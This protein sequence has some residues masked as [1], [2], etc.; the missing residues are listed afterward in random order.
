MEVLSV[1]LSTCGTN[2]LINSPALMIFVWICHKHDPY[3]CAFF[4]FNEV[5]I[6]AGQIGRVHM[7]VK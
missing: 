4:M 5:C 1:Y 3:V 6:N 2:E 7:W